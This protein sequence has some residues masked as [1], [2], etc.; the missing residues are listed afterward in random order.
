MSHIYIYIYLILYS[1][2]CYLKI[3][4]QVGS[5]QII[6][7][8]YLQ[9]IRKY[10]MTYYLIFLLAWQFSNIHKYSITRGIIWIFSAFTVFYSLKV[11]TCNKNIYKVKV[12]Q[13]DFFE[14]IA[15]DMTFFIY[16]QWERKYSY[17]YSL[18]L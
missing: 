11:E 10:F 6:C 4:T 8:H 1:S 18:K 13:T 3:F 7:K 9:A 17:I 12:L 2:I 5:L 15:I 16:I 14:T